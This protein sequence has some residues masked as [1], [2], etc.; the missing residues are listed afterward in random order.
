MPSRR[1]ACSRPRGSS[2]PRRAG[3]TP[4]PR[5][6][7]RA[8]HPPAAP[9]LAG[10]GPEADALAAQARVTL[11]A[12]AERAAALGS[13]EQALGFLDQALEATTDAAGRAGPPQRATPPAPAGA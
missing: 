12:A 3:P 10:K 7:A 6:G 11:R 9:R 13:H 2:P 5:A 1:G 8:G 4:R